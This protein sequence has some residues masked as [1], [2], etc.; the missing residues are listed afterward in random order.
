M[1]KDIE[2]RIEGKGERGRRE[3]GRGGRGRIEREDR[4]LERR[5]QLA[6][7]YTGEEENVENCPAVSRSAA[8]GGGAPRELQ[9]IN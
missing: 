4:R 6:W 2:R 9:P 3:G 8:S 5:D 1:E 7:S